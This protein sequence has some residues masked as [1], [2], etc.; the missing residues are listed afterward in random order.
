MGGGQ[1]QL[2]QQHTMTVTN[3]HEVTGNEMMWPP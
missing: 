2:Q 3:N 1:Q